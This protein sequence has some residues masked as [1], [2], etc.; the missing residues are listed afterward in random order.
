[1]KKNKHIGC[2]YGEDRPLVLEID[3]KN[4]LERFMIERFEG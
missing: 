4:V 2:D 3:G 1:M